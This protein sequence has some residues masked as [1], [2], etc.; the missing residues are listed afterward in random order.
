MLP[1]HCEKY[2]KLPAK[3]QLAHAN[4]QFGNPICVSLLL[5]LIAFIVLIWEWKYYILYF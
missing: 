2:N 5:K 3:E 1:Q 4:Q